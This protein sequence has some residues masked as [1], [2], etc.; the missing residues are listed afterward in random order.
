MDRR[1]AT[2][3]PQDIKDGT[4]DTGLFVG[5]GVKMFCGKYSMQITTLYLKMLLQLPLQLVQKDDS[6]KARMGREKDLGGIWD[7]GKDQNIHIDG[8]SPPQALG[9][10]LIRVTVHITL[11]MLGAASAAAD[12]RAD[13]RCFYIAV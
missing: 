3:L 2:P 1:A 6:D 8:K 12:Y 10:A 5:Q 4:E 9:Q 11:E 7:G 13:L